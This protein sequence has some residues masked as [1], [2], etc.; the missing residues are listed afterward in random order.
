MTLTLAAPGSAPLNLRA[1]PASSSTVV[2][3]WDEPAFPNGII[4]V[5]Q[6]ICLFVIGLILDLVVCDW[7]IA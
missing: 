4:K 2:V 3:Q 6:L 7:F 1:R 5:R